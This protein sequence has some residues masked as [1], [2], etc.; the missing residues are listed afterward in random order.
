VGLR[1]L[2]HRVAKRTAAI[3][4]ALVSLSAAI[5]GQQSSAKDKKT[6]C[7]PQSRITRT[8][9]HSNP[10]AKILSG[11]VVDPMGAVISGANVTVTNVE[12]KEMQK[13]STS[14]EGSFELAVVAGNYSI[15]IELTGWKSLQITNV[16]VEK[17]KLT[18]IEMILEPNGKREWVGLLAAEPSLI[19]SPLG[20]TIFDEKMIRSLPH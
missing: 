9:T 6:A 3:F 18:N 8:S 1:A 15:T 2:R 11:T 4:A 13:T 19:D 20:T 17:N 10:A 14:D 12:T 7:T 5:F 16:N